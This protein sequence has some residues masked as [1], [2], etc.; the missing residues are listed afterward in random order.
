MGTLVTCSFSGR[1]TG[2][3]TGMCIDGLSL[4][5]KMLRN[6]FLSAHLA[7]CLS[8]HRSCG[9]A[10]GRSAG[11][12]LLL[13]TGQD[14]WKALG[15]ETAAFTGRD[16]PSS[17]LWCWH[18]LAV[19]LG[20][21]IHISGPRSSHVNNRTFPDFKVVEEK[22]SEERVLRERGSSK[23]SNRSRGGG[24]EGWRPGQFLRDPSAAGHPVLLPT[25]GCC[26]PTLSRGID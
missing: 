21:W 1:G 24:V 4:G 3:R 17:E 20:V 12:P 11:S 8:D 15:A 16:M 26:H 5:T 6:G 9:A 18:F 22:E 13:S 23:G 10:A 7:V 14:W 19:W 25:S 2:T